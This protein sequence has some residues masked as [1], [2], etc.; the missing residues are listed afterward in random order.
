MCQLG[1]TD[2]DKTAVDKPSYQQANPD[3]FPR[4][5]RRYYGKNRGKILE[6]LRRRFAAHPQH[7]RL[8][9]PAEAG[10][11]EFG[12][13]MRKRRAPRHGAGGS[14]TSEDVKRLYDQQ[15]GCCFYCG[16]ELNA[17]YELDHRTPLSRGGTDWPE[18][19]CCACDWCNRRKHMKTAEEFMEYLTNLRRC[20]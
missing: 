5:Y 20:C 10:Y 17:Q 18:N 15:E 7:E 6:R 4:G 19:L 2:L 11:V 1:Q 9:A 13:E 3:I 12:A 16:K 14:H 8:V